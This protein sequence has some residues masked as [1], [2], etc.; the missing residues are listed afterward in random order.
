MTIRNAILM[1]AAVALVLLCRAE[2]ADK[3]NVTA[4][5]VNGGLRL[6][7]VIQKRGD[8]TPNSRTIRL[9]LVNVGR[10]PLSLVGEWEYEQPGDF[11]AY[12]RHAIEFTTFP[13]V[14]ID[15][16]S[17]SGEE[18]TSPQPKHQLKPAA[19]LAVQ[20]HERGPVL[21]IPDDNYADHFN[22]APTLPSAGMYLIRAHVTLVTED[23]RRLL[24][25]SNE[26]PVIYGEDKTLPKYALGR[27]VSANAENKTA[28]IDLGS[29]HQIEQ[30]DEFDLQN[31]DEKGIAWRLTIDR[32]G[33]GWSE[34]AVKPAKGDA[35]D[36]EAFPQPKWQARL[37]PQPHYKLRIS[38]SEVEAAKVE[39]QC[40]G[41][42]VVCND[43]DDYETPL[44]IVG[45]S[46]GVFIYD[47]RENLLFRH[48][49]AWGP[50]MKWG[51]ERTLRWNTSSN[52]LGRTSEPAFLIP[53][54]GKYTVKVELYEGKQR[55]V[56]DVAIREFEVNGRTP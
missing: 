4:G 20:W 53:A 25:A 19:S 50:G 23:G 48:F 27:I 46:Y 14:A 2:A 10:E 45:P 26:Q 22:T 28:T 44:D 35:A 40:Q 16:A 38:K 13:E 8:M 15:T 17:T 11:A 30:G 52:H 31:P 33:T 41:T 21:K 56:L 43:G 9:E 55:Q 47:A 42:F 3:A 34:G 37:V 5:P 54:P 39:G 7:L 1:A 51:E 24:L 6:R 32:I 18:R 36:P 29:D 49:G 12:L